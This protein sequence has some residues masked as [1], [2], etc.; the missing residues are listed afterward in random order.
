ML[1]VK[2]STRGSSRLLL[3]FEHDLDTTIL[4]ML[5]NVVAVR[6][7]IQAQAVSD[8]EGRINFTSLDTFKQRAQIA[9]NV[10]L[11]HLESQAF[12]EC[13][14]ERKLVEEASIHTGN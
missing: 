10:R 3:W 6:C 5:E 13:R 14:P 7:I 9:M 12:G 11:S 1:Q 4:F 2:V 8:D